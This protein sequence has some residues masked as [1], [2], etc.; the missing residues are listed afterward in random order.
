[1]TKKEVLESIKH[2]VLSAEPSANVLLYGSRARGD[3]VSQSDWDFLILVDGPV[4][5]QR[6]RTL[7]HRL[8]E[9]EWDSGEVISSI[10]LS[11]EEWNDSRHRT[12]PFYETV[13]H[14]G[15]TL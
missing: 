10:I 9:V 4:D 13:L 3:A 1:M 12:T 2:A 5:E 11:R 7:R 6:K 15:V 14:E 8:Y